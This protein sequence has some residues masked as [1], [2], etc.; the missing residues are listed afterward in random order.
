MWED[1]IVA[2]VHRIRRELAEK[3]DFDVHAIVADIRTR[4]VALG[5]RLISLAKSPAQ[6]GQGRDSAPSVETPA[7]P[8]AMLP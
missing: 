2:E 5:S 1:S 4:Q 8:R 3:F 7:P 6:A